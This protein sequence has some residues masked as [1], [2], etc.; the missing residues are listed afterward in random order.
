M[1]LSFE[2]DYW[3]PYLPPR[4]RKL[5]SRKQTGTFSVE[6]PEVT[7][8]EAPVALIQHNRSRIGLEDHGDFR[9]RAIDYRWCNDRF[10]VRCRLSRFRCLRGF[11]PEPDKRNR[12]AL[13]RDVYF[14]GRYDTH[15][16]KERAES[17]LRETFEEYLLIDGKLHEEIGEPRYTIGTYGLGGNHGLGWGTSMHVENSYNPNIGRNRYFRI[18]QEAECNKVG[19]AIAARRGDTKAFPHFDRRYYPIFT[20]L[21]PE[22]LRLDPAHEHGD[23]D[24]FLNRCN[25]ITEINDPVIAGM[26]ILGEAFR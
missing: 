1:K 19:R 6:I 13:L 10:Y 18:D 12:W 23:G 21:M 4:C 16:N 5:R 25:E 24:P 8:E 7:S 26:A 3:E 22:T 9:R 11:G 20:I 14:S 15:S 17:S 2:L